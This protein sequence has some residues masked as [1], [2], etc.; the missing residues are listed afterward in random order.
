MKEAPKY[1]STFSYFFDPSSFAGMHI[2]REN[3][4]FAK[5]VREGETLSLESFFKMKLPVDVWG[6][7]GIHDMH[8]FTGA[9]TM[10]RKKINVKNPTVVV[11][12]FPQMAEMTDR[13][14]NLVKAEYKKLLKKAGFAPKRIEFE[15]EALAR[16][17]SHESAHAPAIMVYVGGRHSNIS[18]LSHGNVVKSHISPYGGDL[19]ASALARE[20]GITEDEAHILKKERGLKTDEKGRALSLMLEA[21]SI[22]KDDIASVHRSW[23]DMV[24]RH[25]GNSQKVNSKIVLFGKHADMAGLAHYLESTL[26]MP[27]SYLNV[28]EHILSTD[29]ALPKLP[30][31]ES[32]DFAHALSAAIAGLK[33]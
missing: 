21:I 31:N 28:W 3:I 15:D 32:L 1:F 17:A 14:L 4:T 33:R 7:N 5:L 30:F 6:A 9:L 13:E 10:F 23:H 29:V 22:L 24:K 19:L 2:S 27:V 8:A 18:I 16:I 11:P 26:K 20:F 25:A 12:T